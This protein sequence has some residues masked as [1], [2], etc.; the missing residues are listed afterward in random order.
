LETAGLRFVAP[1]LIFEE[2][3][4]KDNIEEVLPQIL[5]TDSLETLWIIFYGKGGRITKI[6]AGE[7]KVGSILSNS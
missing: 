7:H 2:I 1:E 3:G 4:W 6:I 5:P